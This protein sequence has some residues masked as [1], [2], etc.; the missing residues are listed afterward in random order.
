MAILTISILGVM[1]FQ[2]TYKATLIEIWN[3]FSIQDHPPLFG[4]ETIVDNNDEVPNNDG[5]IDNDDEHE[6]DGE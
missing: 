4:N 6:N 2:F 5:R 3:Q 1:V